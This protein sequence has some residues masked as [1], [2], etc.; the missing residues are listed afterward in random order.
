MYTE[1]VSVELLLGKTLKSLVNEDNRSLKFETIDG[2][3]YEMYHA[4]ECCEDVIIE[5]IDGDLND[6]IGNPIL[7]AEEATGTVELN[8]NIYGN[9]TWTFYKF[10]TIKG[11][12]TIRW[13]GESNG[14][15]SESVDFVQ[16]TK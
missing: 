10:A 11:Y 2:E 9:G 4:Q 13:L 1:R 14:Y 3:K 16:I 8:E 6:L 5:D 15:Y 12:V 7:Q